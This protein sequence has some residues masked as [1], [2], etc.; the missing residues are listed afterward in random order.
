MLSQVLFARLALCGSIAALLSTSNLTAQQPAES[1]AS[2]RVPVTVVLMDRL[3]NPGTDALIFR[4]ADQVPR[5]VIVLKSDAAS[6]E[7]LSAAVYDLL[8]IRKMSGDV[9]PVSGIVRTRPAGISPGRVRRSLPWAQ[10]VVNDLQRSE[11]QSIAG[12]GS[13]RAVQIWLPR[14][15]RVPR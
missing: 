3:P 9:A 14:Q 2:A 10:R 13:G 15:Q 8:T 12:I 4:R 1:T 7:S 6:G 5:D 11:V